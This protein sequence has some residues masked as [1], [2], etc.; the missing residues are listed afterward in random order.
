VKQE[1]LRLG[2]IDEKW[3]RPLDAAFGPQLRQLL[4][5]WMPSNRDAILLAHHLTDHA[6]RFNKPLPPLT[7]KEGSSADTRKPDVI[8]DPGQ[9]NQMVIKLLEQEESILSDLWKSSELRDAS[10]SARAQSSA[11]D[12]APR[13]F[14]TA[15]RD[16]HRAVVWYMKLKKE[17]L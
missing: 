3:N 8:P 16:L 14:S 13:Y 1:F 4:T 15:C 12:F 6:R 5:E 2:R 17:N 11:V 10:D 7:P 9:Q